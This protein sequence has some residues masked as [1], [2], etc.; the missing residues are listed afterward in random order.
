MLNDSITKN[1]IDGWNNEKPIEQWI[2]ELT[3]DEE[4]ISGELINYKFN[5]DVI[6]QKKHSILGGDILL[7]TSQ[8]PTLQLYLYV[9]M[10][11]NIFSE[12]IW[13]GFNEELNQPNKLLLGRDC[14]AF[15]RNALTELLK[16][17]CNDF[18]IAEPLDFESENMNGI[19]P[20]GFK[21]DCSQ[22]RF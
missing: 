21:D 4:N 17:I 5:I 14:A 8:Y 9:E 19:C 20:T 13:A 6:G 10:K 15:N 3:I 1:Q 16:Q 7:T 22:F 2:D 18:G 12:Y 11:I